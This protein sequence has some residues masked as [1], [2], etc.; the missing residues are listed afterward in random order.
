MAQP[1]VIQDAISIA[2]NSVNENV[3]VS[4]NSLRALQRLPFPAQITFAA[5]QSAAGLQI[6]LNIGSKNVVASSNPRVSAST[7]EIPLDVVNGDCY[8]EEGS[9]LVL[10]AANV[11]G[12]ALTLRYMIIAE[13]LAETGEL[14]DLP[15]DTRVMVQGPTSVANSSVDLQLLDGLRYERAPVDAIMEILMTQSA[16][17]ITRQVF[18]AMDRIAP[19]S[20][21]SLANRIPQDPFDVTVTGI[22]V[23]KDELIQLSVTNNSGGALN[24]FW[25]MVLKE[26]YRT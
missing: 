21:I 9:L 2:A 1:V 16:A 12:G 11:T 5:V 13:P 8:G 20:A 19:A 6:D 7:P 3:I 15:P 17:G 14:V 10:R 25:K 24:V 4:N 26:L 18:V 22:Q 23:P